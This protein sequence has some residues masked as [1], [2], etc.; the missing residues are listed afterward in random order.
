M[1]SWQR[2]KKKAHRGHL[3][4]ADQQTQRVGLT[5]RCSTIA[6]ELLPA[7][8]VHKDEVDFRADSLDEFGIAWV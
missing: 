6:T 3:P 4:L 2:R 7:I 1:S 5:S 8:E